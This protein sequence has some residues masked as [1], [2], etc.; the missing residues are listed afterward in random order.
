M[1]VKRCQCE[2]GLKNSENSVDVLEQCGSYRP[3]LRWTGTRRVQW[4]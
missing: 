4:Y 3:G 2:T 1:W